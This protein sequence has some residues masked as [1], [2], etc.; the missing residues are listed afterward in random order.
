M[1]LVTPRQESFAPWEPPGT[2]ATREVDRT[3]AGPTGGATSGATGG[4]MAGPTG[5]PAAGPTAGPTGGGTAARDEV[6]ALLRDGSGRR[7]RFDPGLSGGLRAWLEDAASELA[8]ARGEDAGPLYLGPRLLWGTS[9]AAA[10]PASSIAADPFPLEVVTSCLIRALF[11]QLVTTG[12][13]G[14][15]LTDALDGLRVDPDRVAMVRWIDE[16][17]E[18][19]RTALSVTLVPHVAHLGNLTPRFAAGW[20]PRT[21]DRVAIPLAGG[22]VVLSGVF[23]LLVGAPVPGTATLC[24]LGLTTGGRWA[25]ARTALHYLAVLETLR[26]GNP[27]FRVALLHS[28]LGRYGV[29]D[30]REEHLRA[31]VSHVV[32]RLSELAHAEAANSGSGGSHV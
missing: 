12:R 23:D 20:L 4:A 21:G 25:Q 9:A 8:A 32:L 13:L 3:T 2:A 26:S 27:P 6:L 22:R 15:P 7:P 17:S 14:D 10:A 30:V 18:Q 31:I 5:G 24:A 11:R 19:A 16:M 28:A 1:V 29:E